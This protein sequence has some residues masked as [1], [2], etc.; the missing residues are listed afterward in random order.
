MAIHYLALW[1]PYG[2]D[3]EGMFKFFLF[4]WIYVR[5]PLV[6]HVVYSFVSAWNPNSYRYVR[7]FDYSG[8]VA[9]SALW[10]FTIA[11]FLLPEKLRKKRDA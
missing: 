11:F 5:D 3:T 8:I 4:P 2:F 1:L 10:G 6:T 7:W 9:N